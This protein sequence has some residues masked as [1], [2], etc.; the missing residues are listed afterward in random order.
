MGSSYSAE[1][2]HTAND[3]A[4]I[5]FVQSF[6]V[7]SL[8][9]LS[10]P[11]APPAHYSPEDLNTGPDQMSV[12]A[13]AVTSPVWLGEGPHW[14]A[15]EQALFFV[16]IFDRSVN[17]FIPS[18]GKQT[19]SKLGGMPTYIIPIEGRPHHYV[20]SLDRRVV[21]IE[22]SGENDTAKEVKTIAEVD[23]HEP[24]NRFNDA[25]ADPRGRLF[26]GTMGFEYEPGKF[27]LKKGS[28]YR[29]EA[30]GTTHQV[31]T[32]VDISNGLCWDVNEKAFYY[33][34]SFE[35]AIRRYDYDIDTGNISNPRKVF[36]F[37]THGLAGIVD[38]M[39]IDTDGNL[40]VANFD[41]YQVLK[42]DPRTSELLQKV[43]IPAL[44]VTSCTFG[45][46][47]LDI[48]YV[49]TASMN[50]GEE[51]PPPRGSTFALTG[52]G[53]KGHP[54]VNV[55]INMAKVQKISE[56]LLLGEGPHWD[57]DQQALYFVSIIEKTIHKY[58]PA[59]G[60]YTKTTLDGRP[61]FIVPV[62]GKSNE[63]VVGVERKFLVVKWDGNDGSPATVVKE[64]AEVDK[65]TKN[66][67]NDGKADP[68]GRLFAGTMGHEET[69]GD[70][71]LEQGALYRLD[72][73][74]VTQLADKISISNGLAWDLTEKAFYYTDSLEQCIR[75]YDYDVET[76][77]ISNLKYFFDF[78]K[79]G[80]TEGFPDG[81]TIDTDGNLWVAVFNGSCILHIDPRT[82]TLLQ[83]VPIPAKQ[84]TS[85]TFGGPNYDILFVTT[86]SVKIAEEQ[87]PPCGATFMVT[88]L[89]V[90]GN[91]NV[92]VKL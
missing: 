85:A 3:N 16:S 4:F 23:A 15:S 5:R 9:G 41:G 22:W 82:D 6:N 80:I 18:T 60:A 53:V 84:V 8:L 64:I 75:R 74:K 49:T 42:I 61:G 17:K 39:T 65:G 69:P 50:R 13:E 54:N 91:P 56:E 57:H 68:R 12:N 70:Y 89:G 66:R 52:L 32:D 78:K 35:Y 27:H 11:S 2:D 51:Q 14:D 40:W 46:P 21:E 28:L 45:G 37:E 31:I 62:E 83:K 92:N 29:I 25:K 26:A 48:L 87:K 24:Q 81:T 33:A 19:S 20:V 43:P 72:G 47:N 30:D 58:V 71:A 38:G 76:G 88:G 79:H 44:Q 67:I 73:T 86:A 55:K 7:K 90:K 10:V 59:T 63:F 36:E 34:D 77:N 1:N